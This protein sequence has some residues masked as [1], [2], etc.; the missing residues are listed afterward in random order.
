MK[1]KQTK[2][3]KRCMSIQDKRKQINKWLDDKPPF[4]AFGDLQELFPTLKDRR[5]F[6]HKIINA[7]YDIS[8]V[9]W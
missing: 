9:E 6:T 8:T 3:K 7:I 4:M 2:S 5:N 1:T